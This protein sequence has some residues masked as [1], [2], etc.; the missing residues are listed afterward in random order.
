M[1]FSPAS[2]VTCPETI[3]CNH[4]TQTCNLPNDFFID[5]DYLHGVQSQGKFYGDLTLNFIGGMASRTTFVERKLTNKNYKMVCEYS[6]DGEERDDGTHSKSVLLPVSI[7]VNTLNF[8][9]VRYFGLQNS[10]L[11]YNSKN[12]SD[13][14]AIK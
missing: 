4:E 3:T 7:F 2:V 13:F 11:W 10:Y 6:G 5:Y 9:D 8:K 14:T 12:A 1:K